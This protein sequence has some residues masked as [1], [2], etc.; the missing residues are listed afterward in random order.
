MD[1]APQIEN[2][3]IK[4]IRLRLKVNQHEFA[5]A[6]GLSL[7]TIKSWE[8]G[9]RN[10]TGLAQKALKLIEKDLELYYRFK[11]N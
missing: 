6:L 5:D 4:A 9:R 8:Q 10:P 3:D 2:V 7:E 11:F 1:A